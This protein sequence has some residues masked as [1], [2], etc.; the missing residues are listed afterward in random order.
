MSEVPK[1][2]IS[3]PN[4]DCRVG[5]TGK[6]VEGFEISQCPHQKPAST[7][8]KTTDFPREY[9]KALPEKDP[10]EIPLLRGE[11]LTIDEASDVLCGWPSRVLAIIGPLDSGKTTLCLSLYQA[12]QEGPFGPWNFGGSI[13]IPAF[14]KRGHLSQAECG[15]AKPDT[16]RTSLGE[17]LGFFH[18]GVHS[19]KTG[20]I[21]LL[22]SDRSGEFFRGIA[23]GLEDCKNLPEL[24]RADL[25]LFLVDGAKMAGDERHGIKEDLILMVSTLMEGGALRKSHRIALALTK[26]DFVLTHKNLER[27]KRDFKELGEDLQKRFGSSLEK[28]QFFMIAARPENNS[29]KPRYGILEVLETCCLPPLTFAFAPP[30]FPK[31]QRSF[32]RFG[33]VER[34]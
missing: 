11:T 28:I 29:V 8:P 17:G 25:I 21:N 2:T 12:F 34:K 3:C 15:K 23:D 22:V 9:D 20:L 16:L 7:I 31:V 1:K 6:C 13:T 33:G 10:D 26:Y 4:P 32:M 27:V 18:L 5:E 24:N 14:E 19:E 30:D